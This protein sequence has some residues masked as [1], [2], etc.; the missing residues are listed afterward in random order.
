MTGHEPLRVLLVDD[1]DRVRAA[2][3]DLLSDQDG[4]QVVGSCPDAPSALAL[5]RTQPIDVAVVDVQ[6]P[7]MD[8][9]ALTRLLLADHPDLVVLALSAAGDAAA[10]ESMR[11][12]GASGYHVKG[13]DTMRLVDTLLDLRT[14]QD[15]GGD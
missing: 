4:L 2:V 10:R 12:A 5:A 6:M 8:G 14:R 3:A 9:P 15:G 7:G 13:P 1:D 11:A